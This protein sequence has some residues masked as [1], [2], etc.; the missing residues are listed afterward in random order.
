MIITLSSMIGVPK[1][2]IRTEQELPD[3]HRSLPK[4]CGKHSIPCGFPRSAKPFFDADLLLVPSVVTLAEAA[5]HPL[6]YFSHDPE[7]GDYHYYFHAAMYLF[8]P[9]FIEICNYTIK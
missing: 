6:E 7:H 9:I 2:Y 4:P 5:E 3:K 1:I 8:N